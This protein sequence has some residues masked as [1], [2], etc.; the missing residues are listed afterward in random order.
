M[1]CHL[2][3]SARHVTS[4]FQGLSLSLAPGDGK[5]RTLGTRLRVETDDMSSGKPQ[6]ERLKCYLLLCLQVTYDRDGGRTTVSKTVI[7][8]GDNGSERGEIC[9]QV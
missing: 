1:F 9:Q 7:T 6:C 4:V 8:S 3:D 2:P 5:E